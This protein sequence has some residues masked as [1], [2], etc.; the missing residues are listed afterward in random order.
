MFV[1]L[2]SL[3]SA[4]V[5]ITT[6]RM[7]D[8]DG[9][10]V[11][12]VVGL[13]AEGDYQINANPNRLD[14]KLE[15]FIS[16]SKARIA[17]KDSNLVSTIEQNGDLLLVTVQHPYRYEKLELTYPRSVV[18]D[19]FK[20]N[21]SKAE[22][23]SIADFY[24]ET[25]KLNSADK[26]YNDLHI[27]YRQDTKI[28]YK[29]AELLYKKGSCRA[30][31][32]LF[33]IPTGAP[34]FEQAKRLMSVIHGEDEPLAPPPVIEEGQQDTLSASPIAPT[35]PDQAPKPPVQ[36][37]AKPAT[38]KKTGR[39]MSLIPMLL[40][41]GI[42]VAVACVIFIFALRMKPAVKHE[43]SPFT[44]SNISLDNKTMCRMVSK[45]LSDG[46][47]MREIS[48]E[49]KISQKEVEQLVQMCHSGG[50]DDQD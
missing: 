35:T 38:A 9:A 5:G 32:K 26:T 17:T 10:V 6:V 20:S 15:N 39:I 7:E 22:R 50:Y 3:L 47:S 19:I 31:E 49:L 44:E 41:L 11:R 21:P 28:L 40:V 1:C 23:L 2:L 34:Y 25:G 37:V 12:V 45:L 16:N 27:D 18:I 43:P 48:K 29:W 8:Y 33:L 30:S 4:S 14:F 42:L 24:A 36:P 46:W 13:S